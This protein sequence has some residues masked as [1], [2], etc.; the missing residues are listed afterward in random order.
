MV[1][2]LISATPSEVAQMTGA[3]LKQSIKASGRFVLKMW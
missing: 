2:R 1:K 3:E